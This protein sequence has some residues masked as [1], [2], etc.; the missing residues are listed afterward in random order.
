MNRIN[1]ICGGTLRSFISLHW[2]AFRSCKPWTLEQRGFRVSSQFFTASSADVRKST[3][4]WTQLRLWSDDD[5]AEI[6]HL[7]QLSLGSNSRFHWKLFTVFTSFLDDWV[8]AEKHRI[9]TT[10]LVYYLV[11]GS[12]TFWIKGQNLKKIPVR[13]PNTIIFLD[14]IK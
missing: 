11:R 4:V 3:S 7:I 10:L 2:K 12:Q 13:G 14:V 5:S 9:P 1:W 8:K 6:L